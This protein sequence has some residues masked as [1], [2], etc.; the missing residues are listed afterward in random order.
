MLVVLAALVACSPD[1]SAP[2]DDSCTEAFFADADGDGHGDATTW[3]V[4]CVG[5]SGYVATAGDCDDTNVAVHPG[6]DEICNEVD[7]DCDGAIDDGAIDATVSYV[8]LDGD[9]F[10]DDATTV[11]RCT[12]P[13][14]HVDVGGDCDDR[15]DAVHPDAAE[16]CNDADDDCDELV[17]S[18]DPGLTDGQTWYADADHDHYGDPTTPTYSCTHP[19]GTIEEHADCNDAD[20]AVHPLTEEVC[21]GIDND[22]DGLTDDEDPDPLI[23]TTVFYIDADG[24]GF[25]VDGP[26]TIRACVLPKGWS[27][28][29]DDCD[30]ADAAVGA[31]FDTYRDGDGDGYGSAVVL[32]ACTIPPDRVLV[33]GDCDD[34]HEEVFPGATEVCNDIDDNCDGA[35]DEADPLVVYASWYGDGDADGFGDDTDV[36]VG[37]DAPSGYVGVGGDCDDDDAD[38]FPGAVEYCDS[39]DNDCN[40]ADDDSVVYSDWFADDDGDGYGDD[41]DSLND[42]VPPSGYVAVGGDCDDATSTTWPGASE[43]CNN[44][45]DDDCDGAADNCVIPLDEADATVEGVEPNGYSTGCGVGWDIAVSDIDGDGIADLLLGNACHDDDTGEASIVYGPLSGAT[46][47]DDHVAISSTVGGGRLG[48][49]LAAGDADDDGNADVFVGAGYAGSA[50]LF[51]GPITAEAA[52]RDADA[53]LDGATGGDVEVEVFPDVDGDA[54]S[55]LVVAAWRWDCAYPLYDCGSVYVVDGAS[56]GDVT[57]DSDATYVFYGTQDYDKLGEGSSDVGDAN[58][59]GIADL[60]LA[61]SRSDVV[62]LLD[63]GASPGSYEASDAASGTITGGGGTELAMT[64]ADYDDDGYTDLLIGSKGYETVFAF[65]GPVSGAITTSEATVTWESTDRKT[66]MFGAAVAASDADGDGQVDV[67]MGAPYAGGDVEPNWI[68][69]AY[70]QFGK[71][72]GVIDVSTLPSFAV[73]GYDPG[74]YSPYLYFGGSVAFVPDWTGDDVSE[75]VIGAPV[76]EG[77]T[78]E[79]VGKIYVFFSDG[80]Y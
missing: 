27:D 36:V 80:L 54:Q 44:D 8:D 66:R 48:S 5:P 45:A 9:G 18:L 41:A 10:G 56:V 79:P 68:G 16:I 13:I 51:L 32:T 63:G 17:D 55:D 47:I 20:P 35:V 49:S 7:D 12:T 43:V 14:G 57:L 76:W 25:G 78:S 77:D 11:T 30:D 1:A 33:S 62:Y 70:L 19:E 67:L 71:A 53:T 21:D 4:A 3:A 22:C 24:D 50:Y 74:R 52:T 69:T 29:T 34:R 28:N 73:E 72:A 2:T 42:C 64:S 65:L 39:K 59:D 23:G 37:C 46:G 31:P 58:G 38:V 40:G 6:A 15:D 60:A 75:L 26:K 61:A